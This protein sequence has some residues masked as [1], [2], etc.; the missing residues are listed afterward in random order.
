[1][2]R[3]G[4][5]PVAASHE[6]TVATMVISKRSGKRGSVL[7]AEFALEVAK[8]E[9][10]MGWAWGVGW[11]GVCVAERDLG[12]GQD[13]G[14][15]DRCDDQRGDAWG[16]SCRPPGGSASGGEGD[17]AEGRAA[18]RTER[19]IPA[20]ELAKQ[21]AP[22][23]SAAPAK[24]LSKRD[25]GL[26]EPGPS[27]VQTDAT[28]LVKAAGQ[29][30]LDEATQEGDGVDRSG[31]RSLR[32]KRDG[33]RA[34]REQAGVGEADAVGVAAEVI[35]DVLA[36]CEGWLGVEMPLH[37]DEGARE[38]GKPLGVLEIVEAREVSLTVLA[39]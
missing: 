36:A 38:T 17:G 12:R 26:S 37:P 13:E 23:C 5:K 2:K 35:E 21:L 19:D 14:V 11:T 22:S 39:A 6:V 9:K 20:G 1:M 15:F 24:A 25:P 28:D 8:R 32:A 10:S 18:D 16:K 30:V 33:F 31:P 29:D 34:H 7:S 4:T 27:G 3:D